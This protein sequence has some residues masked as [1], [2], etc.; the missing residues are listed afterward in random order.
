MS[1]NFTVD[2][3]KIDQLLQEFV[4]RREAGEQLD[5][6][7]FAAQNE[8]YRQ[9]LEELLPVFLE[10][11]RC[12]A[13]LDPSQVVDGAPKSLGQYRLRRLIGRGGMG[14]VFEAHHD[15]LDRRVALKLL[16]PW[17]AEAPQARARFLN[18]ARAIAGLQHE[19]LIPI[20]DVGCVGGYDYFAMQLVDGINGHD[21]VHLMRARVEQAISRT[22]NPILLDSSVA[23]DEQRHEELL[24][25]SPTLPA[26]YTLEHWHFAARMCMEAARALHHAHNAGVVHRDVKPS[27]VLLDR[28]GKAWVSDFGLAKKPNS[29][30]TRT[31]VAMGTLRYMA[32]EQ[33][34]AEAVDGRADVYGLGVALFE[35][36][37]LQDSTIPSTT[38]LVAKDGPPFIDEQ[39][40]EVLPAPLKDV[41][42]RAAMP[43][44]DRRYPSAL[45]LAQDLENYVNDQPIRASGP[46]R[47]E[48]IRWHL[49][50]YRTAWSMALLGILLMLI[51]L[52]GGYVRNAQKR[53]VV[54][55]NGRELYIHGRDRE[56]ATWVLERGGSVRVFDGYQEP[57]IYHVDD[58]P[59]RVF[60][61][62]TISFWDFNGLDVDIFKAIVSLK[63][64]NELLLDNCRFDNYCVQLL[65]DVPLISLQLNECDIAD[66]DL[67]HIA[68]LD[69]L[70]W[71]GLRDN[72]LSDGGVALLK[73]LHNL[74]EVNLSGNPGL[75]NRCLR[76]FAWKKCNGHA[77]C[78][79][80]AS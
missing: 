79:W 60:N 71:L 12:A 28:H 66:E 65:P 22:R 39:Q 63:R 19:N 30:L 70:V 6:T 18:E 21:F 35:W 15:P 14:L 80:Y 49:S 7:A 10:M 62:T 55:I 8:P 57:R 26:P 78:A 64:L 77:R 37:T 16:S 44:V 5:I 33:F 25:K 23:N 17:R 67:P 24:S 4:V 50:N 73:P 41:V 13:R 54:L 20:F 46:T 72:E 68:E 27:N 48:R 11:E 52:G 51:L 40:L 61:V 2:D 34:R 9:R 38:Q 59:N 75:T 29:E 42:L 32:P 31:G 1:S 56:I 43:C 47:R 69:R 74:S 58:L 3:E 76:P 36:L 53:D 45:E